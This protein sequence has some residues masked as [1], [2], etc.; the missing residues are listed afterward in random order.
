LYLYLNEVFLKKHLKISD[1]TDEELLKRYKETGDSKYFGML[2][3]RYIPLIYGLCLRY[4]RGE[5]EAQDAVMQI[6]EDLLP[7]IPNY[8]VSSF[9]T[10]IYSVAKNHCLWE[11]R[12]RKKEITVDFDVE[13]ME[14]EEV[15]HLLDEKENNDK[16]KILEEC[17][18]QLPEPQR[19]SI[20]M[21]FFKN[22]SY[23]DI[24]DDTQYH[25]K[26]VKSYIQNGKR[27]LKLCLEKK[28]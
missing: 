22:K 24:V 8:S 21:F 1:F 9:K 20:E 5:E 16:F 25:L 7:K 28:S 14:S 4:L 27:N 2:Y 15:L 13:L 23:R 26:S 18:K 11:I 6:F 12:G 19:V 10:W 17:M 3:N